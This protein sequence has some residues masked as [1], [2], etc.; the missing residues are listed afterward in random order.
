LKNLPDKENTFQAQYIDDHV[1]VYQAYNAKIA[2][3][4][5]K[6]QC[7]GGPD[8]HSTGNHGL[9]RTLHG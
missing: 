3:S 2:S 8:F 9:N 5:V 6:E 1:V 4:A 7:F